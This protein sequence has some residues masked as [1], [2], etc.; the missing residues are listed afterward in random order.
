MK[1]QN[2]IITINVGMNVSDIHGDLM[3]LGQHIDR[4]RCVLKE[5]EKG[6]KKTVFF[7]QNNYVAEMVFAGSNVFT[8]ISSNRVNNSYPY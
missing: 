7:Q 3:V 2:H 5:K 1:S 4:H 6:K 8:T